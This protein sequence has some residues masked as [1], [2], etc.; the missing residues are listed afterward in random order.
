[1][2]VYSCFFVIVIMDTISQISYKFRR[3]V[4]HRIS[5]QKARERWSEEEEEKEIAIDR[6][7]EIEIERKRESIEISSSSLKQWEK[8][9]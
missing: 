6:G 1:M 9:I 8:N 7:G 2:F 4:R 5:F 3:T